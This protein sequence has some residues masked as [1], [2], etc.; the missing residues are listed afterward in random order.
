R[1]L[2]SYLKIIIALIAGAIIS[3]LCHWYLDHRFL[4]S[5]VRRE[6]ELKTVKTVLGG[7]VLTPEAAAP[8]EKYKLSSDQD[9]FERLDYDPLRTWQRV[10][11]ALVQLFHHFVAA[12][13]VFALVVAVA[14]AIGCF[15]VKREAHLNHKRLSLQASIEQPVLA[16]R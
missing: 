1:D 9:V 12:S 11:L 14:F 2:N 6:G 3:H 13:K 5:Q 8:K 15:L 10:P 16:N 7:P 4:Y